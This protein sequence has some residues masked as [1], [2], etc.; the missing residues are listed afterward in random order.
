MVQVSDKTSIITNRRDRN[1][2]RK[3]FPGILSP[4][5]HSVQQG[6]VLY[7]IL[8]PSVPHDATWINKGRET[9]SR[10]VCN[11]DYIKVLTISRMSFWH[12]YVLHEG[13]TCK[14]RVP[15]TA[16]MTSSLFYAN[17]LARSSKFFR[18]GLW[19]LCVRS[20]IWRRKLELL[21]TCLGCSLPHT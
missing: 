16:Q 15:R 14:S 4:Q 9:G 19:R 5:R 12:G 8:L 1:K 17:L 20:G 6:I 2:R 13:I 11:S 21:G 7:C 10:H 3:Q 18:Q